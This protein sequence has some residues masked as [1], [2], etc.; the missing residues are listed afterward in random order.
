MA[1]I[2]IALQ[3]YSVRREFA[4]DPRGTLKKAAAMGY[5]G[6]EFAGEPL[7]DPKELRAMLE[8]TGLVC[9]GWHTSFPRVQDD[10]LDE[11]IA[12][13][14]ALGNRHV[15]VPGLP[16]KLT[17]SR[18]GWLCMAQFFNQLVDKLGAHGMATGYHAH[19]G[20]FTPLEG[21]LPWDILFGHTRKE[22]IMQL[23]MGNALAAG[24]DV[25]AV[26]KRYPGRAKSVHLK[27][28][29]VSAAQ[30]DRRRGFRPMIGEDDIPWK[31]VFQLC[32]T[33]GG[34]D[35]YIVEYES[36]AY[37]PFEAVERCLKALKAM[38]Q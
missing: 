18:D 27:P 24:G 13:N 12:F 23:D 38:G 19:G 7:H 33:I 37:P 15:I 35:C 21:E 6:V 30:E 10:K 25:V 32:E 26:L 16:G 36:D 28:Y 29:S 34:T 11:T 17:G 4:A 14:K 3:L 5:E 22:F 1:R 9:R 8:E 2:P 31:E 20:D